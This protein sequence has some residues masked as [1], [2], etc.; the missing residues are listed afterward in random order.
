MR[1]EDITSPCDKDTADLFADSFALVLSPN[2]VFNTEFPIS[3]AFN[4]FSNCVIET[5]DVLKT[6][7]DL[8]IKKGP[9]PD[10]IPPVYLRY[11]S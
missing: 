1:L 9:E 4:H 6:L 2:S 7:N 10:S 3:T 8:N 5:A 11:R